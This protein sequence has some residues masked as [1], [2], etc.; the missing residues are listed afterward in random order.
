MTLS[1]KIL[2]IL[3]DDVR[4][5]PKIGHQSVNDLQISLSRSRFPTTPRLERLGA[6]FDQ[7]AHPRLYKIAHIIQNL[8]TGHC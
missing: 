1:I 3:V 8:Q 2:G 5:N 4:S 6:A 7:A